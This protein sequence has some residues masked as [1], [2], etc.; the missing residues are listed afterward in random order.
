M[1]V[2]IPDK[3]GIREGVPVEIKIEGATGTPHIQI[4]KLGT[5]E[6][7]RQSD[8]HYYTQ[9]WAMQK[10]QYQITVKDEKH[11]WTELLKVERQSYLS[12]GQEFGAFLVLFV[13][14]SLGVV[15][16]MKKL[17]KTGG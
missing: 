12:F 4:D 13:C 16:W 6:A 10:G 11:T 5:L 14:F 7:R 1:R 15:I 9:F 2:N 17:N 8:G 3:E